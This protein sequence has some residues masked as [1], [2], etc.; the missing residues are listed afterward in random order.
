MKETTL[1]LKTGIKWNFTETLDGAD[2]GYGEIGFKINTNK[3]KVLRNN[4]QTADP[5]TI[6]GHII[7]EVN[8]FTYHGAKMSKDGNTDSEVRARIS[9]ARVSF[10]V[11]RNIWKTNKINKRTNIRLLTNNVLSVILYAVQSWKVTK[12]ICQTIKKNLQIIVLGEFCQSNGPT[13]F[14]KRTP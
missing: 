6:R 4:S 14:R 3:T 8:E 7:E 11:L 5:V 1:G 9:Q 2:F 10:A 12:G 13:K